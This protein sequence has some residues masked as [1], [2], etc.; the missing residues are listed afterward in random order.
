MKDKSN[1]IGE[2]RRLI[3]QSYSQFELRV[4]AALAKEG[5]NA[6]QSPTSNRPESDILD[7]NRVII[8]SDPT[9]NNTLVLRIIKNRPKSA[10][11]LVT[12]YGPDIKD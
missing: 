4:M 11:V 1:E 5:I 10:S 8:H 7:A 9:A 3:D 6:H 2:S 12:I